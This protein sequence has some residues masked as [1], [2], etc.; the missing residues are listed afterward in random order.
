M[1]T[2]NPLLRL[3][4][5]SGVGTA[6]KLHIRRGD[7]LNGRDGSGATPLILAAAKRKK[8][9]VRLLLEA[10]A[11]PAIPDANGM[12][13]LAHAI[14]G[15]CHE[16]VALL[17]EALA[18]GVADEPIK[19]VYAESSGLSCEEDR[20]LFVLEPADLQLIPVA[21][22]PQLARAEV[23]D[24]VPEPTFVEG[25]SPCTEQTVE[26]AANATT[27]EEATEVVS[28]DDEPLNELFSDD[29]VAEED[30]SVPE[31]DETVAEAARKAHDAIGRHRIVDRDEDWGDVD[32]NL[33]VRAAPLARDEGAGAVRDLLLAAIREGMV[34][35]NDLIDVCLDA[36]GGRNEE[37][38]RLLAI[39]VGELGAN[40]VEW[41][42]SDD[43]LRAEPTLAEEDLL[44]EATE[45]AEELASGFND[46]FR[47]YA[48]DIR[49][50]L[51]KPEEEIALGR[52]ME[53]AGREA[54]SA[55]A[56]WPDGLSALFDAAAR[57]AR[58][59]ANAESFCA[60]P[61]PSSDDGATSLSIGSG[62]E[63]DEDNDESE[64]DE[65]AYFFVTA[66]AAVEG[67]REDA[68]RATDALESARL[69][70]GFLVELADR[71][72]R[73]AA[74]RD[75]V[76]ALCRQ[77]AARER[78]ILCNLRLALSIA[79]RHLWSG[80]PFD[81]LVQEANIGLMKAVERYD[82]RRGFRF[83][84]YATW[85]IRQQLS[86]FIADTGR[87]VRAP[88]HVQETARKILRERR[89]AEALLGRP[90]T[91]AETARRA[92]MSVAK[93]CMLLSLFEDVASLDDI[94][95]DT[96]MPRADS[97]G[98]AKAFDP[99][100]VA[101]NASLRITL[102]KLLD[103]LD[104]RSREVI[105]LRFGLAGDDPMT[106]DEIG[107]HFGV[108]RERIRQIESKAMRRLSNW[109]RQAILW[110]FMGDG[111][112]PSSSPATEQARSEAASGATKKDLRDENVR[113]APVAHEAQLSLSPRSMIDV[114]SIEIP[115]PV[116][117]GVETLFAPRSMPLIPPAVSPGDP[118][119]RI[120]HE[121][122]VL[123][124]EVQ[125]RRAEGGELRILV[126]LA[127]SPKVAA[128]V[129]RLRS[130]GFRMIQ[131][132]VFVK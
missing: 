11:N 97:L 93:T 61:E 32:L 84:T 87:V 101:E 105:S 69:R 126:P 99:A 26:S 55:L 2:L 8:D 43:A 30:V 107:Q 80:I 86:R 67:A 98:D 110:P 72:G 57:V 90:E 118:T 131:K 42:G 112:A 129:R 34:S 92:G 85:W 5:I 79:K 128:L 22:V 75:F 78:M 102:L 10:G 21:P 1:R 111:Y 108:T 31:G 25:A 23:S 71:A 62:E 37:A 132:D 104:E 123:G 13:A 36:D 109:S 64:L 54:L 46:P 113:V 28:L 66:V 44:T 17:T 3:A 58:G 89:A 39:V 20:A 56:S 12:D 9:A 81:D 115:S 68:R 116:R 51:L 65:D 45:F 16:T 91:E 106:L 100:G 103:D 96:L 47:F 125:D 49:G 14:K 40:V 63:C 83:S 53:E 82:W 29:W 19:K 76:V 38:E 88:N 50:E 117:I 27:A 41:T 33:P 15:G 4:A 24:G 59:E 52:E 130:S 35:E 95:L 77:A 121:A 119:S 124:L 48:K 6:I 73:D 70:R 114:E 18:H 94:N 120:A 60:G 127:T 122:R 7:D 74:G